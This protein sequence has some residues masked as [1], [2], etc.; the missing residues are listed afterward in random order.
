MLDRNLAE[1]ISRVLYPNDNVCYPLGW[2]QEARS[3]WERAR[4]GVTPA[5]ALVT[6]RAFCWPLS[7]LWLPSS[8]S[9]V[10]LG[11]GVGSGSLEELFLETPT[12]LLVLVATSLLTQLHCCFSVGER[13]SGP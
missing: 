12:I 1:N 6:P 7:V 10:M 3:A 2:G 11:S 13:L 5:G 8:L 9:V 4:G